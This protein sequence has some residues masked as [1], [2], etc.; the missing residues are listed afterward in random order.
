MWK[1]YS[2]LQLTPKIVLKHK[3]KKNIII[4]I[5]NSCPCNRHWYV[6]ALHLLCLGLEKHYIYSNVNICM[7]VLETSI[8]GLHDLPKVPQPKHWE[9]VFCM[10]SLSRQSFG[11]CTL[12]WSGFMYFKTFRYFNHIKTHIKSISS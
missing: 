12:I 10:W 8:K 3:I 5:Y 11:A 2:L 7:S 9:V 4:P 1:K 6:H